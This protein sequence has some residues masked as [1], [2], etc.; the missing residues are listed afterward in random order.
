MWRCCCCW[1][2]SELGAAMSHRTVM[3][4]SSSG[5][6]TLHTPDG[7]PVRL[8]AKTTFHLHLLHRPARTEG[9]G[10]SSTQ[11]RSCSD[12]RPTSKSLPSQFVIM[13][14]R[15][16][17]DL[18]VHAATRLWRRRHESV[19]RSGPTSLNVRDMNK[20]RLNS[21]QITHPIRFQA[22]LFLL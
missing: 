21:E 2:G 18:P 11:R 22:A 6:S 3:A 19:R 1:K 12:G 4:R 8:I 7:R 10:S 13:C 5:T 20:S 14:R 9:R 16:D 15:S 17:T